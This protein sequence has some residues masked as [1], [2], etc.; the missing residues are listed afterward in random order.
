MHTYNAVHCQTHIHKLTYVL[1]NRSAGLLALSVLDTPHTGWPQPCNFSPLGCLFF[2]FCLCSIWLTVDR[3]VSCC[4]GLFL[5]KSIFKLPLFVV[6]K[7]KTLTSVWLC[8]RNYFT[9]NTPHR[10]RKFRI[11]VSNLRRKLWE[12]LCGFERHTRQQTVVSGSI[13]YR[14]WP[15]SVEANYG[16][17]PYCQGWCSPDHFIMTWTKGYDNSTEWIFKLSPDS[18][19]SFH[20]VISA[21]AR[22]LIKIIA[23]FLVWF[24]LKGRHRA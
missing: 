16:I 5:C 10:H 23:L 7:G 21:D 8:Q 2:L 18:K 15:C 20:W 1:I 17:L 9:S 19:M 11:V 22:F 13:G 4:C 12:D 14:K 3:H 6:S 24:T